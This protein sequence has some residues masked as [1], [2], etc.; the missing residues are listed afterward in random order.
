MPSKKSKSKTLPAKQNSPS[1]NT[2]P[3][4]VWMATSLVLGNMI[5]SGIFLLPSVLAQFGGISLIGWLLTSLGA[6]AFA[7]VFSQLSQHYPNTGGLYVYCRE[8]LGETIGFLL[9][10]GYWV[11]LCVGTAA[12]AI[13]FTSYTSY[14]IPTLATNNLLALL[15]NMVI[16]WSLTLI[17]AYSV[18]NGGLMQLVTTIVKIIPIVL[19]AVFGLFHINTSHFTPFNVSE[20]SNFTAIISTISLTLWA[21]IGLESASI[22]ADS[23]ENPE[24]TIPLATMLGT[25]IASII[26]I[27]S[28]AAIIGLVNPSVLQ[29]SSAPFTVAAQILWGNIGGAVVGI[30]A[31]I[32]CLGAI[33]G[34][35]LIQGQI[36]YA[37]ANDGLLPKA[38]T[39]KSPQGAPYVAIISSS[40]ITTLIIFFN[41]GSTLIT[42][43]KFI[44]ELSTI[45]TLITFLFCA[46]ARVLLLNHS[47]KPRSRNYKIMTLIICSTAFIYGMFAVA[48]SGYE[49]VYWCMLLMLA[50]LPIYAFVKYAHE[51]S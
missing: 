35:T 31:I 32:A 43:F 28:T 19:I 22:P 40:L 21:F 42:M 10:W 41:Y 51:R 2:K 47:K 7:L 37:M 34:W 27:T 25:I 46:I 4:G 15:S 14:F 12:I 16:L 39:K 48:S 18:F 6:L 8:E 5:G 26:Y 24:R 36:S 1:N 44:L 38:F 45:Q 33:N 49:I 29:F 23:I 20:V 30:G 9:A 17:N 11:S 3:L 13:S 50:G